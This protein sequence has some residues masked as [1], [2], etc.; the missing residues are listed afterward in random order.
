MHVHWRKERDVE[1]HSDH[2]KDGEAEGGIEFVWEVEAE[3]I[4]IVG[5]EQSGILA[6]QFTGHSDWVGDDEEGV[7]G[8]GKYLVP[9]HDRS[10]S[11]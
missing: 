9:S 10:G 2:N 4:L 7:P 11:T 5:V 3:N 8:G 6:Q 1:Q